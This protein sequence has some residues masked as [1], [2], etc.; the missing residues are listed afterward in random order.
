MAPTAAPRMTLRHTLSNQ[1]I[2]TPLKDDDVNGIAVSNSKMKSVWTL[3]R[4]KKIE[5]KKKKRGGGNLKTKQKFCFDN[6]VNSKIVIKRNGVNKLLQQA[7]PLGT[8]AN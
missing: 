8:L 4:D 3:R 6:S 5:K 7:P 1:T 2:Q